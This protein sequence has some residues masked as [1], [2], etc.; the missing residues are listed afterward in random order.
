MLNQKS[1]S[2][3]F[4][5]PQSSSFMSTGT[6]S[7][8]SAQSQNVISERI[9]VPNQPQ[10]N[11]PKRSFGKRERSFNP[12]WFKSFSW[13]H[14]CRESD[15]V[16]CYICANA[17]LKGNLRSAHNKESAF[18]TTG[19]HNWKKAVSR[20]ESHMNSYC[21]KTALTYEST[22]FQCKDVGVMINQEIENNRN[23]ERR[24]F[25][26]VM[27]TVQVLSGDSFPRR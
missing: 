16:I 20:F 11:F 2:Q 22:V 26:K 7:S 3:F 5:S 17:E 8:D 10:E 24:Y 25:K 27:E 1:I 21:H 9:E 18:I 19:F 4:Q 12:A 13:L 14:Y 6:N 23:V 15:T